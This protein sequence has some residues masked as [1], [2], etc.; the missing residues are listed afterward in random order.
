MNF[1]VKRPEFKS[2][3]YNILDFGAKSEANF[4]NKEAIQKAI[5]TCS[6]NGGGIVFIP[7]GFYLTG[8]IELKDNVNLN[9][10]NNAY[11]KFTKSKEEYPLRFTEY[12]GIRK[13][14][15][16][17]PISAEGKNNIAITS[18]GILD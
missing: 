4:N 12:E 15:A 14:R 18:K 13:I 5:D 6:N 11:V 16:I 17:S 3:I 2:E 7:N 9:L 1:D 10:A 8:P